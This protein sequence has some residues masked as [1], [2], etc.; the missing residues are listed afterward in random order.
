MVEKDFIA[1]D[2]IEEAEQTSVD[3]IVTLENLSLFKNEYDKTVPKVKEVTQEEY[4]KLTDEQK[5][6]GTIYFIKDAQN[7]SGSVDIDDNLNN[8]SK[9]PV[10]NKVVTEALY[11]KLN[12]S[13]GTMTGALI[14]KS[15]S[16]YG[17]AQVRNVTISNAIP[18]GGSY[19]QIHFKYT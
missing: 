19:G 14:A 5:N 7:I 16:D 2:F 9:N 15:N 18:S 8:E 11:D 17:V 6:D 1:L 3:K 13:G 12:K 4:N 10:Q